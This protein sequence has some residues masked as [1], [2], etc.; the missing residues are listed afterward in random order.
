LKIVALLEIEEHGLLKG[1]T[2]NG[3]VLFLRL[4][5]T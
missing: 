3:P 1:L 4:R 5:V 2:W